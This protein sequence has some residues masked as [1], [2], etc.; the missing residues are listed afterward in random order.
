MS[1]PR[2]SISTSIN[3]AGRS[4]LAFPLAAGADGRLLCVHTEP[5]AVRQLLGLV[6]DIAKGE[7]P[8]VPALHNPCD[9]ARGETLDEQIGDLCNRLMS[10]FG[11]I[12]LAGLHTVWEK[13]AGRGASGFGR[14]VIRREDRWSLVLRLERREGMIVWDSNTS[15]QQGD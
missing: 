2:V 3:E 5:A 9:L 11:A 1:S 12:G 8:G 7:F 13:P 14:I 6:R 4:R 10:F 15:I